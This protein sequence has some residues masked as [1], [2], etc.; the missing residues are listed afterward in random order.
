MTMSKGVLMFAHNNAEI[1]Y[2]RLAIVNALLCQKNLG[3]SSE[4]ITIVTDSHSLEHANNTLG[5]TVYDAAQYI[6]FEKDISF[7]ARNNRVYK[8]TF[9]HV[10]TLPFYNINRTDAYDISPYD[11]TLLIDADYLILSSS[12]SACWGHNNDL[13]MNTRYND[14]MMS[15]NFESLHKLSPAG[16]DMYWATVVYFRKCSEE[17]EL[18][19]ELCKYARDNYAY[20]SR[21][22]GYDAR[23]FRNDFAFTIA[24]HTLGGFVKDPVRQLPV[25]LFKT[26]DLDDIHE[27][28]GPN[29]LKLFLEKPGCSG[30]FML[31]DWKDLDIHIMNKWA[32]NRI[33]SQLLEHM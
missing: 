18:F 23:I 9:H 16:V 27:V 5:D 6:L 13:M 29:H 15:R 14:V 22:Y 28:S 17:A 32:L 31:C 20:F 7:K 21:I 12:L 11:E 1:D 33:S 10:E 25:T 8:D 30:D 24:A 26:F 4:Q 2:I 3:L 19:F